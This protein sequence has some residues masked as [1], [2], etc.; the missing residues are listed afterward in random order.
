MFKSPGSAPA[1]LVD[2]DEHARLL[3]LAS[4]SAQRG[5][6]LRSRGRFGVERETQPSSFLSEREGE[7]EHVSMV[8]S[9]LAPSTPNPRPGQMRSG[10]KVT[11]EP[12][13]PPFTPP[14]LPAAMSSGCRQPFPRASRCVSVSGY[15]HWPVPSWAKVSERHP[16]R[17]LRC[18]VAPPA[19]P[20]RSI[21]TPG[22]G[23]PEHRYS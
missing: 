19:H 18:Q 23:E 15:R 6:C 5:L 2:A 11:K 21:T 7:R 22:D 13:T 3:P 14:R 4:I 8:P 20:F 10:N 1:E 12:A 16:D 17:R 9:R